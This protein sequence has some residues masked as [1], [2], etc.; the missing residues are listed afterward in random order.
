MESFRNHGPINDAILINSLFE[1]GRVL[2]DSVDCL[3]PEGEKKHIALLIG[4]F[5]D[6]IDFGKDLEQQLNVY[7]E[8]R[9]IFCNLDRIQDKLVLCTMSLAC[10][11]LKLVKG[12][13][14]KKTSSFVKACLAY[15]HITIP[16]I[17][18]GFRR[19]LLL[20][21]A[22]QVALLNGC[23]PQTDTLL[24]A[25]ISTLPDLNATEDIEGRRVSTEE[26]LASYIRTL[27]STLVLTPGHPEH[28][29][30]YIIAGLLNALPKF[31][32]SEN[33]P[34]LPRLY[35]DILALICTYAQRRFPYH[36]VGVESNDDLYGGAPGYL[37]ELGETLNACMEEILKQL[38]RFAE[39][40]DPISRSIQCK[41]ILDVVNQLMARMELKPDLCEFAV[42]LL[43]LASK[44]KEQM[45]R[46]ERR[47]WSN[48][49][50]AV[51][52]QLGQCPTS[53]SPSMAS[54]LRG[55][56]N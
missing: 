36:I 52:Y 7:V 26:K 48:T 27:L 20:I 53:V 9:G 28:G 14:S 40:S 50:D 17:A 46:P 4:S 55:F 24:K 11:A 30:F 25:A 29:P 1:I 47:Y 45:G 54:V 13:H 16:S 5:I 56:T 41:V 39:K 12:K 43:E 32:W 8:C 2:H 3:S 18:D 34:F 42:K 19:L 10:R 35:V 44:S 23:L 15:C 49:L 31:P 38:T 37:R 22:G 33:S 51:R 21:T 6:K